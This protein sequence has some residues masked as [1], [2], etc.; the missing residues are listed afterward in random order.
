MSLLLSG[1]IEKNTGP[2]AS[3]TTI[4]HPNYCNYLRVAIYMVFLGEKLLPDPADE[5]DVLV[6]DVSDG[7][8]DLKNLLGQ[9]YQPHLNELKNLKKNISCFMDSMK[10]WGRYGGLERDQYCNIFSPT[11]WKNLDSSL[12]KKHTISCS[13]CP[14][15]ISHGMFPS[16]NKFQKERKENPGYAVK[17]TKKILKKSEKTVLKEST[18]EAL[19]IMNESFEQTY[20]LSFEESLLL[21]TLSL[22]KKHSREARGQIKKQHFREAVEKIESDYEY[23]LVDRVYGGRNSLRK[24]DKGRMKQFF[25]TVPAATKRTF[26]EK[27]KIEKGLKKPKNHVGNFSSY[28]IET[29][30]LENKALSW[31]DE[32]HVVWQK[33]GAE[34][35]KDKNGSTLS[36]CGQIAK[37]CL[38]SKVM[39]GDFQFTYKGKD[40]SKPGKVH[41]HKTSLCSS[42]SVPVD[43]S[44]KKAKLALEEK[45]RSGEIDIG[46]NVVEKVIQKRWYDKNIRNK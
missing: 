46:K 33:V 10:Q 44:A 5:D 11:N 6:I 36:N 23:T 27:D 8:A 12:K 40:E 25:E 13:E 24:H 37:G 34:C 26:E 22:K 20:G 19:N 14:K 43:Q 38:L 42:I 3:W 30:S 45:V 1:D 2:G 29:T 32:S 41:R 7:F 15:L 21:T 28:Q 9:Y 31:S 35:I 4:R 16:T 18:N 39:N 17:Q